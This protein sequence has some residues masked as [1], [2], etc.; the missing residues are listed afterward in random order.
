MI[1]KNGNNVTTFGWDSAEIISE[2]MELIQKMVKIYFNSS[3]KLLDTG[4]HWFW[5]PMGNFIEV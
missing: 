3:K 4:R 5:I 2:S 1:S